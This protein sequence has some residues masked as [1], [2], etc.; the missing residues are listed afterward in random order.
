MNGLGYSI[1]IQNPTHS[2]ILHFHGQTYLFK[3]QTD[4][5][6]LSRLGQEVNIV[7]NDV[8]L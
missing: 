7:R 2:V 6:Y 8:L 3:L 5:L 4:G 1:I